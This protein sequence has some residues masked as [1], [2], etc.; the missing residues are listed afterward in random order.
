MKKR[1]ILRT[2]SLGILVI[3][4]VFVIFALS[5]LRCGRTV[6]I[7]NFR[8]GV[9]QLQALCPLDGAA[10]RRVVLGERAVRGHG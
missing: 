7:G 10:V 4:A 1:A 6:H 2:V 5:C 8:F 3:T 9:E